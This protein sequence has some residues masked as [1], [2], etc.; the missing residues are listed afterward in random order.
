MGNLKSGGYVYFDAEGNSFV[1]SGSTASIAVDS[2]SIDNNY[3]SWHCLGNIG[4]NATISLFDDILKPSRKKG[5]WIRKRNGDK[6]YYICSE[7]KNG[8][9]CV[10]PFEWIA[11]PWCDA[12]MDGVGEI[13]NGIVYEPES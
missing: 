5:S 2:G 9:F 1:S 8:D 6:E 7:C 11:C 12:Q 3:L 10:D 4:N 13:H